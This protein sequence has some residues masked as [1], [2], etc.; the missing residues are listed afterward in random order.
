MQEIDQEPICCLHLWA[1]KDC[2]Q[3]QVARSVPGKRGSSFIC[4]S[5]KTACYWCEQSFLQGLKSRAL[6]HSAITVTLAP[7]ASLLPEHSQTSFIPS[8]FLSCTRHCFQE[9]FTAVHEVLYLLLRYFWQ[10]G[11]PVSTY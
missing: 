10:T 3:R 6:H 7:S 9:A 2:E 8:S 5:S 4:L 1:N 11:H